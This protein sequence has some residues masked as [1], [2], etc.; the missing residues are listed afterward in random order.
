MYK[1]KECEGPDLLLLDIKC[2]IA[3]FS[4]F[5][6]LKISPVTGKANKLVE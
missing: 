3:V 2:R 1:K 5:S 4:L 6:R